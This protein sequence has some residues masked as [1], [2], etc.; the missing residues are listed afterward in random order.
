M[1]FASYHS[2]QVAFVTVGYLVGGIVA[3]VA[4]GSAIDA[5]ITRH[6]FYIGRG[7]AVI[8]TLAVFFAGARA[9]GRRVAELSGGDARRTGRQ[10]AIFVAIPLIVVAG[11]LAPLE[12]AAVKIANGWGLPIHAAYLGLFVPSA[13]IVTAIGSFGLGRGLRDDHFGMRLAATS[14]PF[15]ALAFLIVASLMYLIGWRIGEPDAGRRA[16]MLVV[17]AIS[18]IAAA[19]TAGWMIGKALEK[20]SPQ[21]IQVR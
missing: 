12:P 3:A 16:T 13:L 4:V 21:T 1:T 19:T 7:L 17:T 11:G 5:L 10:S 9:W 2:R 18:V 15:A 14:A 6:S 8:G 20:Q